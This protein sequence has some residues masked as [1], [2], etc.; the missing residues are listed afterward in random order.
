MSSV[1]VIWSMVIAA[2]LTLAAVH[3]PV[4]WSNRADRAGLAFS[5]ATISTAAFAICELSM[6]HAQTPRAY[7]EVLR[8]AHVPI[9]LWVIATAAFVYFYLDAGRPWLA[10][11]AIGLRLVALPFNFIAAQNLNYREVTELRSISIL[12]E[13]VSVAV[14]VP[15]PWMAVGQLGLLLL[16]VFVA[17]AT[18][19]AWRRG[20][21]TSAVVVGAS[22]TFFLIA[23][24][25]QSMPVFWGLVEAPVMVSLFY[26][27]VI[28][29]MGYA[30]SVDLLRAKQLVLDLRERELQ[31]SLAADAAGL[32]M[33]ARDIATGTLWASDKWRSLFGF[34]PGEPLS[35]D[36]LLQRI[37][38]D[39][40]AAFR[41]R[42]A[43]AT[44]DRGEYD[45]EYRVLLPDG[46]TRW[47]ASQG[48]VEFDAKRR[49]T[50]TR[51]ASIDI[52]VRKEAAQEML[53]LR[54][55]IAH[56]GR[57]SVMGQLATTLAHEINQP[58]GAILRNAEAAAL[59][60]Q[61]PSPDLAEIGAILEDIR[62]DDQRAGAIIDRMRAMLRR[63]QVAMISLDVGQVLRDAATLLRP[64]AAARQVNLALDVSDGVP[65]VRGDRIQLQQVLLNLI[66]N[67]MDALEGVGGK[68]SRTV[69]MAARRDTAQ[70]VEISVTDTGP[71]IAA[72]QFDRI[73]DPF[74]STKAKGVG[75]GLS[76]S[77]TIVEAHGGR[78]WA[79]NNADG[80]ANLRMTLPIAAPAT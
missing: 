9:A 31:A 49:P 4:W 28:A 68:R 62:R 79:Q 2:C 29:A 37:H 77:R 63:E 21:R 19:T 18:I 50:R 46:S 60:I 20:V 43:E 8:W 55:E 17:D 3:L 39:D 61:H 38:P 44:A 33:W 15:N 71:G 66:L 57:V 24:V 67:A 42:L 32:G 12:G 78:L 72:D 11:G 58:L 5:V 69:S 52:T 40:R 54:Q 48:R 16:I 36:H 80:G 14:G 74:F 45:L 35:M 73:F 65:P 22:I 51:G 27:G 1:T 34:L 53:R 75:M 47:I 64:D 23:G 13:P 6:F 70:V 26:L 30:M 76:I 56:V 41:E 25:A 59:F 7:A 10:F